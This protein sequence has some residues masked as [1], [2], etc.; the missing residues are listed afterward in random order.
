MLLFITAARATILHRGNSAMNFMHADSI[1]IL[2]KLDITHY[3]YCL[4]DTYY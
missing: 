3:N 4:G 2:D 1:S